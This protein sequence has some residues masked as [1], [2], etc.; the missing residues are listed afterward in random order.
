MRFWLRIPQHA[1]ATMT[2]NSLLHECEENEMGRKVQP[3]RLQAL[4]EAVETHPGERAGFLARLLGVDRSTVTRTLPALEDQGF[5][6][7]ED[8]KGRLWP[9]QR[10]KDGQI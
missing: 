4:Y 10:P 1:A 6:L 2:S 9:F 7:S 8:Q 3:D 5:L